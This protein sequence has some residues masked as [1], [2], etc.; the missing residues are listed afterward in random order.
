MNPLFKSVHA[1]DLSALQKALADEPSRSQCTKALHEAAR[2]GYLSIVTALIPVSDPKLYESKALDLAIAQNHVEVVKALIPVSDPDQSKSLFLR[3]AVDL[4]SVPMV[5]TLLPHT[6]PK[7]R[8][9]LAFQ[10]AA[11]HGHVELVEL[12]YPHSDLLAAAR[13][14]VEFGQGEALDLLAT[15]LPLSDLVDLMKSLKPGTMQSFETIV[16]SRQREVEMARTV[17]KETD[18]RRP[19]G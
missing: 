16:V 4:L 6:D 3:K 1:N 13:E 17:G 8:N 18:R 7:A 12:L 5:Q 15:H 19:R 11:Q 9:S 14:M 10:Y 2:F